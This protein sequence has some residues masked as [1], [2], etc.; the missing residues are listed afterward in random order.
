MFWRADANHRRAASAPLRR[1]LNKLRATALIVG[2]WA[3]DAS[4]AGRNVTIHSDDGRSITATL[5]EANHLPAPAVILVPALGHPRDEWQ[6]IAQRFAEQDITAL[7]VD[8]P[9]ATLPGDVTELA[10]WS[11]LV[12]G[13]VTWLTGQPNVRPTAIA[14]AGASVGGSLAATAAAADPRIRAIALI[15]PSTD[16]RGLRIESALRQLGSRPVLFIASRKDPYAAR[17]ARELGKDSQGPR[18][19]FLGDAASH[20]VPLLAAEP[21]LARML[22]DWFQRTLGVN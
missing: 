13:A 5:F 16:Y 7:T 2:L 15:S 20:G 6:A 21:D 17:S 19:T 11:G 12:R 18:E 8:L 22:V 10:G 1:D 14:V 4:A 9:A 3:A